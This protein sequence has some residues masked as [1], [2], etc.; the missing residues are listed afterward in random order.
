MYFNFQKRRQGFTLVELLVVIAIIGVLVALLL[1]AIQ[2][3]REAARRMSCSNN[4]KQLGLALHLYHDVHNNF[5]QGVNMVDG[6]NNAYATPG[7]S[8]GASILPHIEETGLYDTLGVDQGL[9][10]ANILSA[11][12]SPVVDTFLCP[13]DTG[14]ELNEERDG[15]LPVAPAKSNYVGAL[16]SSLEI[17]PLSPPTNLIVNGWGGPQSKDTYDGCFGVTPR[18]DGPSFIG[19][20]DITDGTSNTIALGERAWTVGT[21]VGNA[22]A[23]NALVMSGNS[24]VGNARK[25][26][27]SDGIASVLADGTF[28]INTLSF[29][30]TALPGRSLNGSTRGGF[31]SLHPGGA[32]FAMADGSV[33]FLAETIEFTPL[34][35]ADNPASGV[36]QRLVSRN[37]GQPVGEF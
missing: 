32:Q 3:A 27:N 20:K 22:R 37:D 26:D 23:A 9:L 11:T 29:G 24:N 15:Q 1:P 16:N 5:P 18:N 35:A 36:F 17:D 21:D 30:G 4:L 14:P 13:S 25:M 2:A 34:L 6:T 33:Q 12:F 31:S 7:W 28:G 8:W 10:P 19:F